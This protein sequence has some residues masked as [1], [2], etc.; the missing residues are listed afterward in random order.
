MGKHGARCAKARPGAI[1]FTVDLRSPS[2]EAASSAPA[3]PNREAA[4]P[5]IVG[6]WRFASIGAQID[7]CAMRTCRPRRTRALKMRCLF[8]H[9]SGDI[10]PRLALISICAKRTCR[11]H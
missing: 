1:R 5:G 9:L 4:T 10:F 2:A 8:K 3:M 6:S 7:I 11:P